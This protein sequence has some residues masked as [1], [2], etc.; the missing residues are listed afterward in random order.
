MTLFSPDK[1][2]RALLSAGNIVKPAEVSEVLRYVSSDGRYKD[3]DGLHL[4]LLSNG[5]VQQ[6]KWDRMR[7]GVRSGGKKYFVFTD[8]KSESIYNLM[9]GNKHQLVEG[10]STWT[11]LSR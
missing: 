3:L 8:P 9:E 7:N 1:L 6:F 10:S 2:R 4:I 11:T 5:S